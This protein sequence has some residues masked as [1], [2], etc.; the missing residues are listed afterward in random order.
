[1][2][3]IEFGSGE[4]PTKKGF[5]TCDIRNLTGV[6]FVCPAW[7]ISEHVEANTV[8]NIFSRHFFEHLTFIQ[9]ELFLENCHK[10]LV[11]G[12]MMEM[13]IPDMEFHIEQW[14]SKSNI[15][16]ARAGFWGQQREGLNETWDLHKSGYNYAML[17]EL[18]KSKGYE[19]VERISSMKKNLHVKC[20]KM[21]N[22]DV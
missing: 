18:L 10:I 6:D 8:S 14:T 19:R 4:K 1:M 15:A 21:V 5:K 7:E 17:E 12:G 11:D 20:Y 22:E 13:I 9:G 16:Y 3:N 2:L